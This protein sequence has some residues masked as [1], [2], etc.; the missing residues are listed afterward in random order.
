M[1]APRARRRRWTPAH[2][3]KCRALV[4]DLP[5]EYRLRLA[6]EELADFVTGGRRGDLVLAL[7]LVASCSPST[8]S[9]NDTDYSQLA[10]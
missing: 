6:K 3:E 1:K 2:A 7:A 8:K 9:I 4:Q 5:M 10:G